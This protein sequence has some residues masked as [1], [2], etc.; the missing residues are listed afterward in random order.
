MNSRHQRKTAKTKGHDEPLR[1]SH[2]GWAA[3]LLFVSGAA[4]LSL[5]LT[6]MRWLRLTFGSTTWA[7]ST[8]LV[9]YMLGLGLGGLWGAFL[10]RRYRNG[11]SVYGS[12]EAGVGLYAFL[13]PTLFAVLRFVQARFLADLDFWP[14]TLARFFLSIM[15]LTPPTLLMGATLPVL[16]QAVF[17][18]S[19]PAGRV[20]AL[21]YGVNTL[22]AVA[23]VCTTAFLLFPTLGLW[24]T[25]AAAALADLGLGAAAVLYLARRF[26]LEQGRS[27][28]NEGTV[29]DSARQKRG[30]LAPAA[31]L[32]LAVYGTV[33]FS[34][35]AYE[36]AWTRALAPT[37][38]SSTYAFAAMLAAFLVGIG[39]GSLLMQRFVQRVA[40]PFLTFAW[41]LLALTVIA[42]CTGV[43]LQRLP[44]LQ[45]WLF[46]YFGAAP[47]GLAT[48]LFVAS[49]TVMLPSTLLL[50]ALFPLL[51]H[52]LGRWLVPS[53]ATG[54]LY[55]V[56][57]VGSASGA[58]VAGFW[59]IPSLGLQRTLLVL[60]T[61]TAA[62][63]LVLARW[64]GEHRSGS[65]AALLLGAPLL[66]LG[67][68]AVPWRWDAANL[69]RGVYRFPLDEI[70]VGVAP[71]PLE[72]VA[73]SE[74]LFY[75]DGWTSVIS[76]HRLLGELALRVNGK[77]DASS[78]GDLPTQVLLG[79]LGVLFH[80]RPER[81]AVIGLAS[82]VT[83]GSLSLHE[84][85]Q[86][87]VIEIE[88]AMAEASRF[89]DSLNHRPL[90]RPN[91]RLRFDDARSYLAARKGAYD[92][93][94]SEPS[95]PWM[96]GS[97]SLFTRE[98]FQVA[99]EALTPR[100]VLVQWVQ[101]YALDSDTL[102][103][104]LRALR[105]EFS[106]V[107]GFATNPGSADLLF[108]A[109]NQELAPSKFAR[110]EDCEPAVVADLA[111]VG[112][113]STE[114]LW[115]L[116][117]LPPTAVERLA[118]RS[119]IMNTDDNMFVELATPWSLYD[120]TALSENWRAL[121]AASSAVGPFWRESDLL[122]NAADAA[123]LGLAY[124]E[125]NQE[126][127]ARSL[128]ELAE[129][130]G[131]GPETRALRAAL[132]AQADDGA[133][134]TQA[135]LLPD[136]REASAA[137]PDSRALSLLLGAWELDQMNYPQALDAADRL[138]RVRPGDLSA[139]ALRFEALLGLGRYGEAWQ[140]AQALLASPY[141]VRMPVL[142]AKAAQAALRS[143][144]AQ[145]A[146]VLLRQYLEMYPDS[147]QEWNLLAEVYAQLGEEQQAAAARRNVRQAKE[148][149]VLALH[150]QAR[151]LALAGE[152]EA[153]VQRLRTA[154]LFAPDYAPA[155]DD[156]RK[157]GVF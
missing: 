155:R 142:R 14:V 98:F 58:F 110:L 29:A 71:K 113:E 118:S 33:G 107:Y 80:A 66:I 141:A 117:F 24:R 18:S 95:N 127:A 138:L 51:V 19:R 47:S 72:G 84:S 21:L 112:I 92:L 65:R 41:G 77:A 97:A 87:E 150:Q 132:A 56:N 137:R 156:L 44:D 38:G 108:I 36:V 96:S 120:T 149:V 22:G 12:L 100:G 157:L 69:T 57:T 94:V 101:V 42:F 153:A 89:F 2:L 143:G 48:S 105:A 5:E 129:F 64:C 40:A 121:A 152:R 3:L 119:S 124:L 35:L 147:P 13:V 148:N 49:L 39:F 10:A 134:E 46:L 70:E 76:V 116:L 104:I 83:A 9:A 115:S 6:W 11:W 20:V 32:A 123:E 135:R 81:A 78:H 128:L 103:T 133:A 52:A 151:R 85:V 114:Q 67:L 111:R 68:W 59:A 1:T 8:I 136:L 82:G 26:Q 55:F 126:A 91:V 125:R 34:S 109:S 62:A 154:L 73:Q 7:V 43:V 45:P 99:R 122:K 25:N 16:V 17:T 146:A 54:L 130:Q 50:G 53:A 27:A 145:Q 74:L 90:E 60:A 140:E 79:H 4:S 63:S 61:L 102:A 23:G 30:R 31:W 139:R 93:I 88:P 28:A 106:Y 86:V 75:R 15:A 37:I 131:G 144:E